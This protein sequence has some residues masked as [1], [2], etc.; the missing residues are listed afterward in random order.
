MI[1]NK[2]LNQL[3]FADNLEYILWSQRTENINCTMDDVRGEVLRPPH[4]L[5]TER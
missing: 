4:G 1:Q 5:R 3:K 2:S